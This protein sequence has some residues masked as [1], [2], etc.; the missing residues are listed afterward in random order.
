MATV[1]IEVED[2][3][4]SV[5]EARWHEAELFKLDDEY[6]DLLLSKHRGKENDNF[7]T[8]QTPK[9]DGILESSRDGYLGCREG[10]VVEHGGKSHYVIGDASQGS[11]D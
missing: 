8:H 3:A 6:R 11:E 9:N 7:V 1:S 5:D 4:N 10:S 2:I